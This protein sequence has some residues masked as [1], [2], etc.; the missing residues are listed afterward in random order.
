MYVKP[1]FGC[2]FLLTLVASV[3][4]A[5]GQDGDRFAMAHVRMATDQAIAL[6]CVRVARVG[7]DSLTD[8]RRKIVRAG[9]NTAVL[10]F[11]TDNLSLIL[12]DVY[13]CTS[14]ATL[15]A[16]VAPPPAGPPPPPPP[17]VPTPPLGSPPPPPPGSSK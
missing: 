11:T 8:L 4:P 2:A 12:A 13:R 5:G 9:G 6:G 7:D 1:I 14:A 15:P 16:G 17:G 3:S 10:S